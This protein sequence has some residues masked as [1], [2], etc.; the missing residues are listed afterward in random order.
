MISPGA[1][2]K[3]LVG[4]DGLVLGQTSRLTRESRCISN[5]SSHSPTREEAEA[6]KPH[7]M[8]L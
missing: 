5:L 6:H 2:G 1:C 8:E 4:S 7:M 3:H